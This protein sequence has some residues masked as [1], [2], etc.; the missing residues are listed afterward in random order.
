M[1]TRA[2]GIAFERLTMNSQRQKKEEPSLG[3]AILQAILAGGVLYIAGNIILG[4][5]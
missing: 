3:I 5:D 4:I 1:S 2:K